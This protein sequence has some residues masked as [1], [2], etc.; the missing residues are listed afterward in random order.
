MNKWVF[1]LDLKIF[2]V[3]EFLM[4]FGSLLYRAGPQVAKAL[5]PYRFW[6][7]VSSKSSW[8]VERRDLGGWY[9]WSISC[10]YTITAATMQ[11]HDRFGVMD[12]GGNGNT[13]HYQFSDVGSFT[14]L[15]VTVSVH[16]P[17]FIAP[18]ERLYNGIDFVEVLWLSQ[19]IP[20][21]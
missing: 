9:G 2:I 6:H 1:N 16:G 14:C 18:S 7:F 10:R 11:W 12:L 20:P 13:E 3:S 5:S 19:C 8:E 21:H 17:R 15:R 4:S